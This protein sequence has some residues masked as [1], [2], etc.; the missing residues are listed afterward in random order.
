MPHRLIRLYDEQGT[1]NKYFLYEPVKEASASNG[2]PDRYGWS[3]RKAGDDTSNPFPSFTGGKIND[4]CFHKNRFGIL[5]DEN[6]IFSVAGNFYNFFPISVLN[7]RLRLF[8]A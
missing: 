2:A 1:P 4:I 6:I 8:V 3:S 5:S 7:M